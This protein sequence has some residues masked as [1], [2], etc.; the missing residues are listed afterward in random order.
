MTIRIAAGL[1]GLALAAALAAAP[2]RAL[3]PEQ[4][5]YQGVLVQNNGI[6]VPNGV[7]D[8][9]FRLYDHAT[10]GTIVFEQT[11][12]TQVTSGL[13]NVILSNNGGYDLGDVVAGNSQLFMQVTIL[14][15]PPAV[16]S[17]VTLLPRQQLA[18]VPYALAS[19][20]PDVTVKR[21][22]SRTRTRATRRRRPPPG[23]SSR[24]WR[25][26]ASTFRTSDAFWRCVRRSCS[27]RRTTGAWSARG[28]SGRWPGR[29][30]PRF[31]DRS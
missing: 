2:A 23:P 3:A 28:S 16:P 19:I 8:L 29:R 15:S 17:D 12:A 25:V 20:P 27:P 7:Y 5:S 24:D 10:A 11:L 9:R 13:Y 31:G 22:A 21:R 30:T 4:M 18:S 26:S 14:A 6:A 1:A